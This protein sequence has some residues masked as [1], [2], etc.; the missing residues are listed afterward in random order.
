MRVYGLDTIK[1]FAPNT[2][3]HIAKLQKQ[4]NLTKTSSDFL[5]KK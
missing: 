2:E 5:A 1:T 4:Y 3:M